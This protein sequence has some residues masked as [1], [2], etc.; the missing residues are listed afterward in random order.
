MISAGRFLM[1]ITSVCC[2]GD[3]DDGNE[4]AVVTRVVSMW[5]VGRKAEV[6]VRLAAVAVTVS[7]PTDGQTTPKHRHQ[8]P[9]V[10]LKRWRADRES[11]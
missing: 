1:T 2:D 6:S 4:L 11:A 7:D 9:L 3:V 8:I 5:S 10:T